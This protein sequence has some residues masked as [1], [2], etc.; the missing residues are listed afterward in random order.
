MPTTEG[1]WSITGTPGCYH[2][3]NNS[4]YCSI[5]NKFRKSLSVGSHLCLFLIH[6]LSLNLHFHS[7]AN[8][9]L[10]GNPRSSAEGWKYLC[11]LSNV[12]SKAVKW[13]LGP[14]I[15]VLKRL[16]LIKLTRFWGQGIKQM[17]ANLM[18]IGVKNRCCLQQLG[19]TSKT[20]KALV[21]KWDFKPTK[22]V[23][24]F[25]EQVVPTHD[26]WWV[27]WHLVF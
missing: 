24:S 2:N 21:I 22:C 9:Q 23:H 8:K 26:L 20:D 11:F 15:W 13:Q 27:S 7:F 14:W 6:A 16:K 19:R 4:E 5:Y 17:T 1:S 12:V 18:Q 25:P 3:A 10:S